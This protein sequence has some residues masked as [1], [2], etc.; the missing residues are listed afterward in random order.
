MDFL[1][2]MQSGK[3]LQVNYELAVVEDVA[4]VFSIASIISPAT[5]M[6]SGGTGK[7]DRDLRSRID[8]FGCFEQ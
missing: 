5:V 3:R 2:V 7:G 8:M 4:S 6:S 1:H